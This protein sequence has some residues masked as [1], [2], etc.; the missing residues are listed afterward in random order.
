[1][2][3][4]CWL[5]KRHIKVSLRGQNIAIVQIKMYVLVGKDQILLKFLLYDFA[6][7]AKVDSC[8]LSEDFFYTINRLREQGLPMLSLQQI[9]YYNEVNKNLTAVSCAREEKA[10]SIHT[11]TLG[12]IWGQ[13]CVWKLR[14]N[15]DACHYKLP[16]II[17]FNYTE[18]AC[19]WYSLIST[20]WKKNR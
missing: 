2:N 5:H 3:V 7:R 19:S 6:I 17:L 15:L 16:R 14:M 18:I 20:R 11:G 12:P 9:I 1:M 10:F 13:F 8:S 4:N